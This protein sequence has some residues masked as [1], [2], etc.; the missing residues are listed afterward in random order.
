MGSDAEGEGG[1]ASVRHADRRW[2]LARHLL[3]ENTGDLDGIME[4]FSPD[5]VLQ[6]NDQRFTGHA[7]IRA[8]HAHFG[9]GGQGAFSSLRVEERR[10]YVTSDAI[11]LELTLHGKHSGTWEDIAPTQRVFSLLVCTVYRF[12]AGGK[13]VSEVLYFDSTALRQQLTGAAR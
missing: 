4:T 12:D 11:V 9:F 1:G 13:L 5:A 10:R 2:A 3:A 7:P 6:L 8:Q